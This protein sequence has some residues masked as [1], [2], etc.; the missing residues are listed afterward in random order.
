[1]IPF[2]SQVPFPSFVFFVTWVY[3]LLLLIFSDVTL[4][5]VFLLLFSLAFLSR[6]FISRLAGCSFN[7]VAPF[8]FFLCCAGGFPLSLFL[9]FFCR[10][11]SLR[12]H[13]HRSTY[14]FRDTHPCVHYDLSSLPPF[15]LRSTGLVLD[16]FPHHHTPL[17]AK[18]SIY[19]GS[20]PPVFWDP[21]L[22]GTS[23]FLAIYIFLL[24]VP[25][26]PPQG[27]SLISL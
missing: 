18:F 1:V 9:F 7:N 19:G 5:I 24:Y 23:P 8:A 10:I 2:F 15:F 25:S 16:F 21:C 14:E 13:P 3:S 4:R 17:V 11:P 12:S 22:P 6:S 20:P 27:I 26:G